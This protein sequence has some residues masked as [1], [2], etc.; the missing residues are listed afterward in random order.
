MLLE[1]ASGMRRARAH[2]AWFAN[3]PRT[4]PPGGLKMFPSLFIKIVLTGAVYCR[5]HSF[6]YKTILLG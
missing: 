1:V 4:L 5:H 2:G 3:A 6:G